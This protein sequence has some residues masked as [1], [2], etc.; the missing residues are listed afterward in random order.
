M[1]DVKL[2]TGSLWLWIYVNL[3]LY[4]HSNEHLLSIEDGEILDQLGDC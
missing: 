4:E 3:R 2:G 1:W